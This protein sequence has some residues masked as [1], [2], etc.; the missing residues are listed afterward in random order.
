MVDKPAFAEVPVRMKADSHD[1]SSRPGR[2]ETKVPPA[3]CLI[4]TCDVRL[5]GQ[6]PADRYRRAFRLIGLD[7]EVDAVEPDGWS[8]GIVLVRA[9]GVLDAPLI[10]HLANT[11]GL[12]LT[13]TGSEADI[14]LGIHAPPGQ[15]GTARKL[16]E[17]PKCESPPAPFKCS[18]PDALGLDFWDHLRKRE[19]PYAARVEKSG[20]AAL[21][22]RMFMGTYK[23][24]TDF[25]TKH[26]WPRPA[27][28]IT[29]A[30]APLGITPNMVTTLSAVFVVAAYFL[31]EA[32]AWWPGLVAAWLMALL[33]TV[34]GKLARV[35]LNSSRWGNIFDHGIDLIHPPFWY[36]AWAFG[37]VATGLAPGMAGL[38]WVL[39]VIFAGYVLQRLMEGIAIAWL[40]LEIHIWRRIDTLFR[41]I[42]ARRNPNMAI[43]T[44]SVLFGRPDLGLYAVAAWIVICLILHG[45]QL[46]QAIAAV[47]RHG[48]LSS[49]LREPAR[50]TATGSGS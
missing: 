17:A 10:S 13:G 29:R 22:W 27:F 14:V 42:T 41:Q 45:L 19:T 6:T 7:R 18:A 31:F 38:W 21:E 39:G 40:K 5:W 36:L 34:D 47:R 35:T 30:I 25:V 28:W 12:V 46:A 32:G 37:L 26:I 11:P 43:L 1:R 24:A 48:A 9:D 8:G 15:A 33:D 49:W 23:G 44:V 2:A 16:I 20:T 4:G 3:Y 50:E